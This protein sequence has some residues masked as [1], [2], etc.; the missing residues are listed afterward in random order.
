MASSMEADRILK[1]LFNQEVFGQ[2]IQ[3]SL[4]TLSAE[5]QIPSMFDLEDGSRSFREF[6]LEDALWADCLVASAPTKVEFCSF[7]IG[8]IYIFKRFSSFLD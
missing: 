1:F 7:E 8:S 3:A 2:I 6:E 4:A 5:E